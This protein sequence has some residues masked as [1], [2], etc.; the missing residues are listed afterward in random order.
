[1]LGALGLVGLAYVA[2]VFAAYPD[3]VV[4]MATYKTSHT[5]S[6][7]SPKH[8]APCC[9]EHIEACKIMHW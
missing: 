9:R 2:G 8:C 4:N 7:A 3:G 6:E 5:F 1:M